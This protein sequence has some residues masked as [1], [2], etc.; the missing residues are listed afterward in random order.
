[1]K[2]NTSNISNIIKYLVLV[3]LILV[4]ASADILCQQVNATQVLQNSEVSCTTEEDND[5]EEKDD[6]TYVKAES[7]KASVSIS[8]QIDFIKITSHIQEVIFENVAIIEP[9]TT[10]VHP[11]LLDYYQR[12][13]SY[14][15]VANAP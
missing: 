9:V 7:I 12:L 14:Y 3:V 6:A 4:S 11:T 5:T 2:Q 8:L 13:F 1:M 10:L 15:I